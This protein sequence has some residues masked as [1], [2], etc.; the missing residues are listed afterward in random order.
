ELVE[1][2]VRV[3]VIV[4]ADDR[5]VAPGVAATQ[6]ALLEHGDVVHPV[7]LGQVVGRGQAMPAAADD[8]GVVALL[9]RRTA[10][11]QRP[12]LVVGERVAGEGENRILQGGE[13]SLPYLDFESR[14]R[15]PK[16]SP[17]DRT[18]RSAPAGSRPRPAPQTTSLH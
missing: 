16:A 13:G 10:P 5:R 18:G 2:R 17:A 9:R 15:L 3:E 7:F 4:G 1:M 6:P 11:R 8:D 12:V 14:V